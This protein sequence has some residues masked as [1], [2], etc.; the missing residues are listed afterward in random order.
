M[1][2]YFETFGCSAN[3]A[4]AE[5]MRGIIRN[6]GFEFSNE[7]YADIYICNSCTV[8]YTTEQKILHKIRTFGE[9]GKDV[10]VC[11]CMPEV[12]LDLILNA[13]PEAYIVGVRSVN[14]LSDLL[15]K[16]SDKNAAGVEADSAL[17]CHDSLSS[18][19]S[20]DY[21][22]VRVS[23][24]QPEG[25]LNLPKIRYHDNIHICQISTGCKFGCSYCIVRLARGDLVSFPPEEIIEDV[26]TAVAEG[27][28]EIWLTSQ[29]DSQYGMDFSNDS[30]YANIRL[31]ELLKQIS[32]IPGDFKIRVGM[33]NPFS[34]LPILT[35]LVDAFDHPK[36]YK[37]LHVPIQSAS[38]DVLKSMNRHYSMSDVD[39]VIAVFKERFPDLTLFTD[40]IVGFCGETDSD[41][42][43]T[44][45]WVQKY[46]PDKINISKYSPRPGTKAFSLRNL[47]S[48][49]LTDRSRDLT[50]VT[51]KLK[52]ET[53][54]QRIGKIEDVFV[55]K[56]GKESGVL[57]RTADYK[58]VV[59]NEK[60]LKP[61][62]NVKARIIEA[63]PGY[64][65]GELV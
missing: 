29:D 12:Q 11:G 15:Q 35:E 44:I 58:P 38:E 48:R 3:Q 21:I 7:T 54:N 64:F 14:G 37:F 30:P 33:M 50:E 60:G 62:M 28:S 13:N 5:T 65:I 20:L 39:T 18:L 31:P 45:E 41:F 51:D 4:S 36:I 6:A 22:P 23:S 43:K 34:I 59:L 53:K 26:K 27:C 46:K 40:I 49:I 10:I 52:L 56:Y 25:F 19:S 8:K 16:I 57:A 47:D 9:R 1:K 17:D 61:G 55:S 63:T 24:K 42:E 32:E 2:I